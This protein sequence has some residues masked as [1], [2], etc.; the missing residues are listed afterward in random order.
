MR[1]KK[2]FSGVVID[3]SIGQQTVEYVTRERSAQVA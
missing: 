1:T 2:Q 3:V